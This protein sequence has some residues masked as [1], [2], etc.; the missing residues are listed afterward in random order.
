LLINLFGKKR[1]PTEPDPVTK[2][3]SQYSGRF[4]WGVAKESFQAFSN[5]FPVFIPRNH[6]KPVVVMSPSENEK[7]K[8]SIS[9]IAQ[10]SFPAGAGYKLL[11]VIDGF[12]D[13]Y[14]L[15][16]NTTYKWDTCGPHAIIL[17][18]GGSV[19]EFANVEKRQILRYSHKDE[20]S[21]NWSNKNGVVAL[22]ARLS[23]KQ[24]EA[25]LRS[26]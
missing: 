18:M 2:F 20:G 23:A 17:A 12:S 19:N 1:L 5:V 26:L 4:V 25:A 6:Q 10:I 3:Q 8:S 22:S 24:I 16:K 15:S 13:A 11:C 21:S 7:L 14:L 9:N